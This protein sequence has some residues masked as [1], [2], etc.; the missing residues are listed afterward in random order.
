M[1]KV[2]SDFP[3]HHDGSLNF[4]QWI[5]GLQLKRKEDEIVNI[6]KACWLN[7]QYAKN[8]QTAVHL[9]C[10][11][12]GLQIAEILID[13]DIDS[14][15]ICAALVYSAVQQ[16]KLTVDTINESLSVAVG[17]IVEGVL[18]MDAMRALQSKPLRGKHHSNEQIENFRKML[19]AMVDD[20]RVVVIKLAEQVVFLQQAKALPE[21]ERVIYAREAESIYAPLANRLGIGQLKWELEDLSFRFLD[22]EQYKYIASNLRERRLDREKYI[23]QVKAILE[24]EMTK[25]DI[26]AEVS[27]RVKH[28]Y[29]IWR[30]MNRKKLPFGEIYDV[31]AVRILVPEI[32]DCYYALGTVHGLW[33]HIP[34][35]FDDYIATPKENGYRSLHTAVIGPEGKTLE[36]QIRTHKMHEESE[37][38]VAAHWRYKDGSDPTQSGFE[39][40]MDWLRKFI[41]WQAD[42]ADANDLA[43]DFRS[44]VIDDRIYVFSPKGDVVDL[45]QGATAI[46][47]AYRVHTEVGHRCV[48][49]KANGRIITLTRPLKTGEQIEILTSKSGKPSR[50][51]LDQNRGFVRSQR[52]RAKIHQWFRLQN[53]EKNA[54]EGK[55]LLE[56]ELERLGIEEFKI[57]PLVKRFNYHT[58]ED[59]YAGIGAGDVRLH[60]LVNLIENQIKP[61]EKSEEE[62]VASI[63]KETKAPDPDHSG[64]IVNGVGNLMT[65]VA[66][67]C[68]P[69]PGDPIIGFI[70]KGKGISVHHM[71]C[72]FI[73]DVE[74]NRP[75]RLLACTWGQTEALYPVEVIVI[76]SDRRG[77]LSDITAILKNQDVNLVGVNSQ[78]DSSKDTSETSFRLEIKNLDLLGRVL[79]LLSQVPGVIKAFRKSK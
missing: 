22:P 15:A 60:T 69:V 47:F 68:H 45:P 58:N 36:V 59:L 79:T 43:D 70:T 31:R 8:T 75:E 9:S 40:K 24:E 37:L 73:D 20:V 34:K 29:S 44:E 76:A 33:Q 5:E 17:K 39:N 50:D 28:I 66:A 48:G 25:L 67:C 14:N 1:V 4:S 49:A 46:D 2:R 19:I 77:L 11:E 16:G 54:A 6:A 78:S 32:K 64:I 10:L 23:K 62:M 71:D 3:L 38:G 41:D 63:V 74:K 55:L 42:I 72:H 53:R 18:K 57:K 30:K 35:E 65:H 26:E 7:L 12:L 56:K 21:E 52:A 13:L 51:W 61:K 27:A